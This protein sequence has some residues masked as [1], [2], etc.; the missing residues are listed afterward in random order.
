MS[1]DMNGIIERSDNDFKERFAIA[2]SQLP[3]EELN[4][5][6]EFC[7]KINSKNH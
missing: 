2:L 4:A 3:E 7:D 5:M 1:F 6:E